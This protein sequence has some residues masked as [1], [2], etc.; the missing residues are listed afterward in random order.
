MAALTL[1]ALSAAW[2]PGVTDANRDDRI[3][4]GY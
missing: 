3:L 2:A 4:G 1:H